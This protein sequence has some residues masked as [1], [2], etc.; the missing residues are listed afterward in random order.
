M[1]PCI[2]E[3]ASTQH[4]AMAIKKTVFELC[5]PVFKIHSFNTAHTANYALG[6]KDKP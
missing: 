2:V 1:V 5:T 3:S 6:S 4:S